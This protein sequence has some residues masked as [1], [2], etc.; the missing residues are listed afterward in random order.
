MINGAQDILVGAARIVLTGGVDNMSMS[1]FIVRNIR[2]GSSL[3]IP[4]AFEDSLWVN[5][6][7]NEMFQLI[8]GWLQ[9][10]ILTFN[11]LA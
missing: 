3:G 9:F 4:N 5:T 2:F 6:M 1:P 11:R 8:H 7:T 10:F